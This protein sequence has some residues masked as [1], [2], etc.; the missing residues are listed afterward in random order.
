MYVFVITTNR[1]VIS[2]NVSS[3][4]HFYVEDRR[5][6]QLSL[7]IELILFEE[8]TMAKRWFSNRHEVIVLDT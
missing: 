8:M 6:P 4:R 2:S 5:R 1:K 7:T 3:I